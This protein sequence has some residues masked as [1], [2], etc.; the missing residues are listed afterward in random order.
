[1]SDRTSRLS[2]L[3]KFISY[4]FPTSG[5]KR[6][7]A[8]AALESFVYRNSASSGF[9]GSKTRFGLANSLS[10]GDDTDYSLGELRKHS[11]SL[12]T[13]TTIGAGA[14]FINAS[15]TIGTGLKMQP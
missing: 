15:N 2:G 13:Y 9:T 8:K 3:D 6:I 14:V 11:R 12:I 7:Q 5:I 10:V 4:I 1:M